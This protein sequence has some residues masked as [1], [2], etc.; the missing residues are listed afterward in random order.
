MQTKPTMKSQNMASKWCL[1][2]YVTSGG[3]KIQPHM[4][5]S[6]L[7]FTLRNHE[8]SN[9]NIKMFPFKLLNLHKV[10]SHRSSRVSLSVSSNP[11]E[12]LAKFVQGV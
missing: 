11:Q 5:Q 7:N 2:K 3:T 9:S 10:F 12:D 4:A 6:P 8:K 1:K